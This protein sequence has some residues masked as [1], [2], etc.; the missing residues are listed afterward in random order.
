MP[1]TYNITSCVLSLRCS[2]TTDSRD[3]PQKGSFS[4]KFW[5]IAALDDTTETE[6]A[7]V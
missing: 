7:Y 3:V 1:F 2:P 6:L 5:S 4:L